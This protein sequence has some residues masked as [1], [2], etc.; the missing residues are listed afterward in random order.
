[1]EELILLNQLLENLFIEIVL[2]L[3]FFQK[4]VSCLRSFMQPICHPLHF[5]FG[6]ATSSQGSG[7]E[8]DSVGIELSACFISFKSVNLQV[9]LVKNLL[10]VVG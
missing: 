4:P 1:M 6:E 8:A 10:E 5:C 9:D 2:G 3:G 7:R